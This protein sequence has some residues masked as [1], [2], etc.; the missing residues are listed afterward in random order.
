VV[1]GTDDE[2]PLERTYRFGGARY[3]D[4]VRLLGGSR[5]ALITPYADGADH[6]ADWHHLAWNYRCRATLLFG[7]ERMDP[8]TAEGPATLADANHAID[9]QR[10]RM[11]ARLMA[12]P[13]RQQ[14]PTLDFQRRYGLGELEMVLVATLLYHPILADAATTSVAL[15]AKVV[16]ARESDLLD[17]AALCGPRGA[18]RRHG[19]VRFVDPDLDEAGGVGAVALTPTAE[20]ELLAG[21]RQ[22][23][24][25]HPHERTALHR[26]LDGTEDSGSFFRELGLGDGLGS[27][28]D[29]EE[30]PPAA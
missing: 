25:I 5:H 30:T 21:H 23:P 24:G 19:L 22:T 9:V 10:E 6:L 11:V 2:D 20:A 18:L 12:T 27:P 17:T 1:V 7:E 28:G 26:V 15:C 13:D 29:R 8:L 16:A 4:A 3:A 14:L